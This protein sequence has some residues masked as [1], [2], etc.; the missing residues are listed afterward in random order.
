MFRGVVSKGWIFGLF[1]LTLRG[2]DTLNPP[3]F[4]N[5]QHIVTLTTIFHLHFIV[6]VNS[7]RA[8]CLREYL[9]KGVGESTLEFPRETGSPVSD[10]KFLG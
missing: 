8:S 2:G 7:Q 9:A 4:R 5:L 1:H 3:V 6:S 10:W